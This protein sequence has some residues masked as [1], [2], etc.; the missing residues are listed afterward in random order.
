MLWTIDHHLTREFVD[1]AVFRCLLSRTKM[2]SCSSFTDLRSF[3]SARISLSTG[4]TM[5]VVASQREKQA[6]ER[7]DLPSS[8]TNIT[9]WTLKLH[10]R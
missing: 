3:A 2:Y 8:P 1:S 4:A 5:S 10:E 6:G 7:S 9:P